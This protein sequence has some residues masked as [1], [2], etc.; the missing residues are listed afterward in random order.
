MCIGTL[1]LFIGIFLVGRWGGCIYTVI[2]SPLCCVGILS[3]PEL[4]FHC[5]SCFRGDYISLCI[6]L[7]RYVLSSSDMGLV[8]L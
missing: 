3:S 7:M 8:L 1:L 6:C 5:L 2:G 4:V